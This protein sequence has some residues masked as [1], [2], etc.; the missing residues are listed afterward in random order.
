MWWVVAAWVAASVVAIVV[1]LWK[2]WLPVHKTESTEFRKWPKPSTPEDLDEE[3][4][5]FIQITGLCPYC[6]SSLMEGPRG[7]MMQNL[8]C[9]AMDTCNSRFNVATEWREGYPLPPIGQ[10]LG[11]LPDEVRVAMR[12]KQLKD[13]TLEGIAN[14]PKH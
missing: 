11:P 6:H 7:G 2:K 1:I 10:Y 14:A 9:S 12:V 5:K 4:A 3:V 8:H 13:I